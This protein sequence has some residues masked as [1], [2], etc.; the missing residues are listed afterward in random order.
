MSEKMGEHWGYVSRA[1]GRE[2]EEEEGWQMA[3]MMKV[4]E[5]S[6]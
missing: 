6:G 2:A 4:I 5:G 1:K 3:P